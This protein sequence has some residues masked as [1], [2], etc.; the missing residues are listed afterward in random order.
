MCGAGSNMRKGLSG[1]D[2]ARV[3]PQ[4]GP[5]RRPEVTGDAAVGSRSKPGARTAWPG[6]PLVVAPLIVAPGAVPRVLLLSGGAF[7]PRSC[8]SCLGGRR[9]CLALL[10]LFLWSDGLCDRGGRFGDSSRRNW[11]RWGRR[12]HL[13]HFIG[14]DH[15]SLRWRLICR[16]PVIRHDG[17]LHQPIEAADNSR[18]HG[19]GES[20]G[21][22]QAEPLIS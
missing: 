22:G 12:R 20:D 14:I 15:D 18:A 3:T 1:S 21:G 5:L 2:S 13:R 16:H 19:E 11:F 17:R 8:R 9:P 4:P 7:T 6:C 10:D